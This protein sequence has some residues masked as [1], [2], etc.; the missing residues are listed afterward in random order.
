MTSTTNDAFDLRGVLLSGFLPAA[1]FAIGEGAIIPIIPIAADSLGATLA[2]A[3]FVA[4]LILVGELI[5]DVPSGVVVARIGER[6]AMI[7][8]AVVSVVGLL[9]CTVAPNPLVLAVGVFLVGLSTAVFA[10]ARHAYMTTAIPLR[11]R[12]RALSSLGGVFRFG[13]FVGPFLAAGVI[14]LTGTT[15]S[16]FWVHV[17]CCLGAA[18][19][20]LVIRDPATGVRGLQ[21]P[22]R[23]SR[24]TATDAAATTAGTTRPGELEGEQFV[25]EESHGL[26]RT[27]RAHH[28]VLVR[29]G[30]GAALI[31]AMRAGRQVILPLW[32]VSVGLDDSTAALVIGIAGAVDFALFYTSGQIMDRWGRL[33]SALPCMLGLSICYFLLAWSDHLDARVGWFVAVAMAMSLANGVGSG[34]LMTLGADL[35]PSDRPAPFLGAWRFT[36][37]LGSAAAPLVISGVTALA[38]IAVASGVMGVLGLVGAGILLRYVPRYLPRTLR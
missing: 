4:S 36:G 13:Y 12:A 23:A 3:G 22:A 8:A 9:V 27:I 37:D 16:A 10:L 1:L 19:V 32:A 31:G 38:T 11:I 33:A 24:P 34:I 25:E 18:V 26:F 29:L 21:R 2:V 35:A 5:G 15:Q 20:L 14:H 7:G 6:N 17:V 28:R 30:S